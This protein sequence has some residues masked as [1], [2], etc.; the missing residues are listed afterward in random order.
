ML[1]SLLYTVVGGLSA[2]ADEQLDTLAATLGIQD[3]ATDFILVVDTSVSMKDDGRWGRAREALSGLFESLTPDDHVTL[4]T[5]DDGAQTVFEGTDPNP[6]TLL[7]TLPDTPEGTQTDIGAAIDEG[8]EALTRDGASD[9]AA[10]VLLTDGEL[11]A[12]EG[13][14]YETPDAPA[15]DA[16][17][18]S[19]AAATTGRQVGAFALSLGPKS[20]AGLLAQVF[21]DA[22]VA[23]PGDI[24]GFLS[25]LSEEIKRFRVGEVLAPDL[26]QPV[27]VAV[28]EPQITDARA[29]FTATWT[30]TAT[31]LPTTVAAVQLTPGVDGAAVGME[32]A[33]LELAPG[34]T[35][36]STVTL[37]LPPGTDAAVA[38][39]A[40][41]TSPWQPQLAQLGLAQTFQ[42][43]SQ[44]VTL[45]TA[46]ASQ[47]ESSATAAPTGGPVDEGQPAPSLLGALPS[48]AL[49]AAAGVLA[50]VVLLALIAGAIR[51][52]MP[53]LDGSLALITP[54][55]DVAD[56]FLV[57]GT[58]TRADRSGLTV[59]AT[60]AKGEA[61]R[62]NGHLGKE[63]FAATLTDGQQLKLPDGRTLR[64][65][66]ERSRM[67][68]MINAGGAGARRPE[69]DGPTHP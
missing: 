19:A 12:A 31:H 2:A 38:L 34:Q 66:T 29:T 51:R 56:E 24:V 1:V 47:A 10:F 50:A 45:T 63:R 22:D 39:A 41:V 44:P 59:K 3:Q 67:L 32:P 68:E 30:S 21:P 28:S 20:D 60:P 11:D 58:S 37:T 42:A 4:I 65:T 53:Q 49:A 43:T 16:L 35:Q 27:T 33:T 46:A 18:S 15:W 23:T 17:R 36:T 9:V 5:F 13:S 57:T 55:G 40:T 25:G 54:Q 14:S 62:L 26:E 61:I 7:A 69:P 8:V 48:W 52:R 6:A 64:Y